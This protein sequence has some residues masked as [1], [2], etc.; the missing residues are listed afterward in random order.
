[1]LRV[2][3]YDATQHRG[4]T[5]A[6]VPVAEILA[7]NGPESD[8]T[9]VPGSQQRGK[10]R[11]AMTRRSSAGTFTRAIGVRNVA[12]DELHP[13]PHNPRY[14][15]D[16]KPMKILEESIKKVGIL[17]PLTV[18]RREKDH[19]YVILDGQRRWMC[20]QEL[21][22]LRVPVNEVGEP[23]AV[24][25]IVMMFTIH[26]LR[27][28]WELMP[29]AL[30][31]EVLMQE[32][33]TRSERKLGVLTGLDETTVGRCKKLL[34][35]P[36]RYQDLMLRAE[37]K[38]RVR[39]DF[40]IELYAI[41]SDRFVASRPW[42]SRN[43]FTASMLA[44][45]QAGVIKSV[46]HFRHLKQLIASAVAASRGP[47]MDRKLQAFVRN[48]ELKIEAVALSG[49]GSTRAATVVRLARSLSS[50]LN[51]LDVELAYGDERMWSELQDL[52]E[53]IQT[54]IEQAQ[55][56]LKS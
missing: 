21:G 36:R 2:R 24:Q 38:D 44:K 42:F 29:T 16:P 25:N 35:F 49:V 39:A 40:F 4:F 23:D 51:Q 13:N 30:K 26:K 12:T 14:L 28:D 31:L 10:E 46:I 41:L 9:V 11:H 45:Y 34:S 47:E 53:L 55:R 8:L 33:R 52:L 5:G 1:M 3:A 43:A 18:Y 7:T 19:K 32:L 20:A 15:F 56:R 50:S 54:R 17:V 37:P 22:I 27:K 6:R 48:R